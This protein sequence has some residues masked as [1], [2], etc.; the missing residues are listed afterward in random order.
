MTDPFAALTLRAQNVLAEQGIKSWS[1]LAA[2][3]EAE[4]LAWRVSGRGLVAQLTAALHARGLDWRE[5]APPRQLGGARPGAGRPRASPERRAEW[6]VPLPCRVTPEARA[7][8]EALPR[9]ERSAWV[10]AAI[11]GREPSS[12]A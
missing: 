6:G 11:L 8:V 3:S 4:A 10:S 5:R 2:V 7:V 1:D 9:E 12:P